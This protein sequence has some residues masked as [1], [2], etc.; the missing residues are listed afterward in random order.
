MKATVVEA[1]IGQLKLMI[2]GSQHVKQ[3]QHQHLCDIIGCDSQAL[4]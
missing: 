3:L 2:L 4:R 1:L